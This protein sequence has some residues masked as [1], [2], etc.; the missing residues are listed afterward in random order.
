MLVAVN[1]FSKL[2]I[3]PLKS[4]TMEFISTKK[5]LPD[6]GKLFIHI[7]PSAEITNLLSYAF[8]DEAVELSII[9]KY[10]SG[11]Y[12]T[13]GGSQ[14]V[15]QLQYDTNTSV[16]SQQRWHLYSVFCSKQFGKTKLIMSINGLRKRIQ[17]LF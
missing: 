10:Y 5:P 4:V 1:K 17:T 15:V 6:F 9:T 2:D 12:C 16:L 8:V 7:D 11:H 14:L 13:K 3:Q